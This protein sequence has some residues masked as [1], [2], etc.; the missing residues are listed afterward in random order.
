MSRVARDVMLL[1]VPCVPL[2]DPLLS[3]FSCAAF[4]LTNKTACDMRAG[5]MHVLVLTSL[6]VLSRESNPPSH[7][8]R[9]RLLRTKYS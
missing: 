3:A 9:C 2:V 5:I 8:M 4:W 6:R 1:R 7:T